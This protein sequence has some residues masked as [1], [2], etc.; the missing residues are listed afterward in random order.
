LTVLDNFSANWTIMICTVSPVFENERSSD[1]PEDATDYRVNTAKKKLMVQ[2][3]DLQ[4]R[5]IH[6]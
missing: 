3:C 6:L 4:G 5:I 1:A 2:T